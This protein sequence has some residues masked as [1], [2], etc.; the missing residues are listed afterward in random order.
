MIKIDIKEVKGQI[1]KF[2]KDWFEDNGDGCNAVVGISGGKDSSVV[3]ALCVE[4]L[5]RDRVIGVLMPCGEQSDIDMSKK[6]VNYL[7]IKSY[8]I[9]INDSFQGTLRQMTMN[10]NN[11]KPSIQTIYNLQP[12]LRMAS[13]YAVSQSVNGRVAGTS[14]ASEVYIG[15]ETR[16][17][18]SVADFE[19]IINLTASEVVE[20]G[21]ELG[22]PEELVIKVPSDGLTGKSDEDNFGFT[23][24]EL[25]SYIR[26]GFIEDIDHKRKIEEMHYKNI[27]KQQ[28]IPFFNITELD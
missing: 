2:I 18:D 17:G 11:I 9:N 21:R 1:I 19:P 15:W 3:A 10:K 23:Y 7:G 13:L 12:R 27:F 6:L 8:E 24:S 4:A 16:W 14:N 25:D 28:P 22:L 26:H 20:L 5:G